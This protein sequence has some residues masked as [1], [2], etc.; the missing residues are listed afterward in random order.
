MNKRYSTTTMFATTTTNLFL[1]DRT[2]DDDDDTRT[3]GVSDNFYDVSADNPLCLCEY[4][5]QRGQRSHLLMCCCNCDAFDTF[6]TNLCCGDSDHRSSR[7]RL[8]LDVLTDCIDRVR[9]PCPGGARPIDVDFLFALVSILVYLYLGT[10]SFLATL[11]VVFTVPVLIYARFFSAR[12]SAKTAN[13]SLAFYILLVSFTLSLV[14]FNHALAD[15]IAHVTSL[16]ERRLVNLGLVC[17][18]AGLVYLKNSNPGFIP[19]HSNLR[20]FF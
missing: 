3:S 9:V 13:T 4:V 2:Q 11:A 20:V 10:Y 18:L 19:P 17:C 6:C 15:E 1:N 7:W 16:F 12:M 14:M 8:F 5:N